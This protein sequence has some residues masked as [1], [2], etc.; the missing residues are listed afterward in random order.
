LPYKIGEACAEN[1]L[2]GELFAD[3]F[4]WTKYLASKKAMF[5]TEDALLELFKSSKKDDPWVQ[6]FVFD[7]AF[8]E[9][10]MESCLHIQPGSPRY[11]YLDGVFRTRNID[12]PMRNNVWEIVT[13]L[14]EA[15]RFDDLKMA[16]L[17]IYCGANVSCKSPENYNASALDYALGHKALGIVSMLLDRGASLSMPVG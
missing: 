16:E 6:K 3:K 14:V 2:I 8:S 17:L 5:P 13:P 12:Y 15:I 9:P 4:F 11:F 10:S 1:P 7:L